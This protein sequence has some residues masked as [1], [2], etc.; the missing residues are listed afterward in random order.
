MTCEIEKTI[1]T[2]ADF[3]RMGWHDNRIYQLKYDTD[4]ELDID[5]IVKWNEPQIGRHALHLL[6][7]T[8]NTGI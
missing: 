3:D 1:F 2:E 5:Y 8:G 7:S 6:D 4:L